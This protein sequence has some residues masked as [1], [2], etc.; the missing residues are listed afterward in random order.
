MAYAR[1]TVADCYIRKF[2]AIIERRRA[3]AR[4]A[5]GY[6]YTRKATAITERIIA[7][8]RDAVGYRY[9]RKIFATFEGRISNY[10]RS[11]FYSICSCYS[12]FGF[13]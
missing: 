5:V 13:Y 1:D 3:Y 2:T 4:D 6:R 10:I 8:A 12:I 7:Y 11:R 9:A